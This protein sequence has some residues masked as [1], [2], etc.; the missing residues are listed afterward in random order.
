MTSTAKVLFAFLT[1]TALSVPSGA[2][3][4][5]IAS[6]KMQT[7]HKTYWEEK[8]VETG[9]YNSTMIVYATRPSGPVVMGFLEN[10]KFKVS[11]IA[12]NGPK[13]AHFRY[14]GP[15]KMSADLLDAVT[16]LR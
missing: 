15:H 14:I 1:C 6:A 16:S 5:R 3:P 9:V 4:G 2:V 13:G 10:N 8:T 7:V 11:G 12:M